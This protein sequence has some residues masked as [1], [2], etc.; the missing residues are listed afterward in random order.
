MR[1]DMNDIS[2]LRNDKHN[3]NVK[4]LGKAISILKVLSND[5]RK[6]SEISRQLKI[7]KS[8]VHRLLRTLKTYG[9]TI[10]DPNSEE[11]YPGPLVFE[12]ASNPMKYHQ[13][14]MFA[15]Y[16]KMDEL[17]RTT[18][19]TISLDIQFGAEKFK[20]QQ[21]NGLKN[22]S[23]IGGPFVLDQLWS[24][25]SGKVILAQLPDAELQMILDN[26]ELT[27]LTP[28]TITDKQIFTQELIKVKERGY[29]TS[30]GETELG[31]A[32]IAA[33]IE[34]YFIPVSLAMIGP[35][36][37]IT[38]NIMDSI[39]ALKVKAREI[40]EDLKKRFEKKYASRAYLA[41]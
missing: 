19:E 15:T 13:Y 11:Y 27:K 10:Q 3:E 9:L 38:Q 25:A 40:S 5:T 33:P 24:G 14:L 22:I 39:D 37:R 2:E 34:N 4:S 29:S 18:G 8:T 1:V 16:S 30:I 28:R 31:V 12:I 23:F 7:G 35:E 21:L 36:N 6:L 26:I 32:G 17:R 20:L 41:E